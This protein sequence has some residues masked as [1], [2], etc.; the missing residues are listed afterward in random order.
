MLSAVRGYATAGKTHDEDAVMSK[1]YPEL[2]PK[3]IEFIEAQ[4]LFF[5]ATAPLSG[6]GH[7]NVSP[8]G[9]DSLRVIDSK[10][11]AY[12]DV[13]GSGVETISHVKEN[14]R[15]VFMFC[16]FEGSPLIVRVHGRGA[17]LESESDGFREL[18]PRFGEL[19]GVR[20]IIRLDAARVS[21]SCGW[22]VPI[23]QHQGERDYYQK[24]A[25]KLGPEGIREGQL[26][27]NMKSI[28]GLTGLAKP[29][30]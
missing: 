10:T 14:G 3:L 6:D 27:A 5:V 23:Y 21:D 18:R 28:D 19:P 16:A 24:H 9:M 30:F 29:S 4:K 12:L 11:L 15:L 2:T 1:E 7:V 26:A 22:N 8:K 20:A 13:T 17:V 25:D